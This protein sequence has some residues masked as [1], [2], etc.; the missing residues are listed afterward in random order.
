MRV[1]VVTG[2][3]SCLPEE[4]RREMDIT[5]LPYVLEMEGRLL[6]DGV[7]IDAD[8]FYR[9]LPRLKRPPTTSAIS[10]A[11]FLEA[12]RELAPRCEAILVVTIS[13]SFSST[14]NNAVAAAASF[15]D[16][17][18]AVVDSRTAAIACGMVARRAALE[19]LRGASL[20]GCRRAAEE[21]ASKVELLACVD[22]LEQ[23]RRSGRVS[24]LKALAAGA[25]SIRPVLRLREGEAVL[26]ARK[27]SVGSALEHIADRVE[28]AYRREGPL[29]LSVFHASA[30]QMAARLTEMI[31][32]RGVEAAGGIVP[33]RFTPMMG[34]HTGPGIAGAAFVPA[35][36]PAS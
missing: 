10:P 34:C 12:F 26:E 24:V 4:W 18:V 14:F 7:D 3:Q 11:A 35:S 23:L 9:E 22:G 19:S 5:V 6:R 16:R 1:A 32:E 33:T 2:S 28:Q 15:S 27:R 21:E 25:L 20:E 30:P 13:S 29:L 17:P 36:G 31:M 8:G